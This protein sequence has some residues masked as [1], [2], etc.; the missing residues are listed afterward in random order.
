MPLAAS[1]TIQGINEEKKNVTLSLKLFIFKWHF[2]DWILFK[3]CSCV[4]QEPNQIGGG[5]SS[6]GRSH[7]QCRRHKFRQV[8]VLRLD[9]PFTLSL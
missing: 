8:E 5:K 6:D 1:G 2:I 4:R 3:R 9:Y 7:S